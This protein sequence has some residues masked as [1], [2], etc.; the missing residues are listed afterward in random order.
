M[1]SHIT[2]GELLENVDDEEKKRK[3][4]GVR[5]GRKK[6]KNNKITNALYISMTKKI[7]STHII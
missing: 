3:A 4:G 2:I 7:S 6:K 5:E 1:P